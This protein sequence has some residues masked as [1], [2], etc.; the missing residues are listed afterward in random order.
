MPARAHARV[1]P[2]VVLLIPIKRIEE[3]L[4]RLVRPFRTF[5]SMM[6]L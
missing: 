4:V 5:D 3:D 1:Q 6:R 2:D